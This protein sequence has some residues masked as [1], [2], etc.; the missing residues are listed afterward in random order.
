MYLGVQC[1]DTGRRREGTSK[2]TGRSERMKRI[3]AENFKELLNGKGAA[4]CLELPSSVRREV[5]V[6]EIRQ[7]D[8]GPADFKETEGQDHEHLC[9]T[10]MPLRN[11]NLGN[12]RTT[13][14][15]TASVRKQ[16]G[17]N[18]SRSKEG[19]QEN[20]GRVKGRSRTAEEL[21]RETGE[22]KT[23]AGRIR[24]QDGG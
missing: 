23:T 13:T 6:E 22:K 1:A 15:K 11:G 18:N 19:S 12:D 7:E 10:G 14:T 5:E 3:W 16:L 8:G 21:D 24:G 2:S 20:N 9:D 17:P 4:S